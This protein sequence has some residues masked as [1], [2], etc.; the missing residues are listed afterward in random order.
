MDSLGVLL[1]PDDALI[2]SDADALLRIEKIPASTK[3]FSFPDLGSRIEMPLVSCDEREE[4][5]E[6][7]AA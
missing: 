7:L 1:V 5:R 2:Q 3:T 4:F 6:R